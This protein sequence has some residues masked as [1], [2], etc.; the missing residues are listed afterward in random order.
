VYLEG[1]GAVFAGVVSLIIAAKFFVTGLKAIGFIDLLLNSA[2]SLGL[3]YLAMMVLLVLLIVG[4]ALLSGSGNAAFFSFS[5][6]SP[7]VAA[8]VGTSVAS[9][10]LPMQLASGLARSASP[11]A[12]VVIA[13]AAVA[14]ISP[15]EIVKRTAI[16]M[17]GGLIV[18]VI[19][20]QFLI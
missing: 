1:M 8:Q 15:F 7:D 4:I 13:C 3:G 2:S 6:L 19:G 9:V 16:P 12:G 10:A 18:V 11:V 17:A 5:N 20:S 14:N